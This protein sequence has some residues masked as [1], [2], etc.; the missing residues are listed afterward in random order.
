LADI[1]RD[2]AGRL[3]ITVPTVRKSSADNRDTLRLTAAGLYPVTFELR[4]DQSDP[5]ASVLS[6]VER[7]DD[8]VAI[9]PLSVALVTSIESPPAGQPDGTVVV[10]E[11]ARSDLTQLAAALVHNPNVPATVSL[12]PGAAPRPARH[13]G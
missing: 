10:S 7:T 12:P 6:F 8:S 3:S 4:T 11:R 1:P 9:S 5:V 2:G 13:R